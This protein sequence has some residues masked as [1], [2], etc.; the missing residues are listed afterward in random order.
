MENI[1]LIHMIKIHHYLFIGVMHNAFVRVC[2]CLSVAEMLI[3]IGYWPNNP[4]NPNMAFEL[5]WLGLMRVFLLETQVSTKGFVEAHRIVNDLSVFQ[6]HYM[7]I[8]SSLYY[9]IM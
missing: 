5:A 1:L 9:E 7:I 8:F 4:E 3:K 6:V 2:S